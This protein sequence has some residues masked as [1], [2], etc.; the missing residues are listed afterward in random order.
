MSHPGTERQA[1]K[2]GRMEASEAIN[3]SLLYLYRT[4]NG[5]DIQLL[6]RVLTLYVSLNSDKAFS[7]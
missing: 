2:I 1:P 6:R 3:R 7:S 4:N 5:E